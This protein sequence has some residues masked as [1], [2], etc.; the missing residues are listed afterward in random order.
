ML[1]SDPYQLSISYFLF[2]ILNFSFFSPSIT[3]TGWIEFSFWAC[4]IHSIFYIFLVLPLVY[5]ITSLCFFF[6]INFELIGSY[7]FPP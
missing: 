7:I 1:Y 6:L 4:V 3:F 5:V 2:T